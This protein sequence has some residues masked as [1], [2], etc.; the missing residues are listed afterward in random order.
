MSSR[1]A[2]CSSCFP[3][4]QTAPAADQ[5]GRISGRVTVEG[6]NTPMSGA[7]VMLM[8][9][10]RPMGPLGPLPQAA[11]DQDGRQFGFGRS[12]RAQYRVNAQ[13]RPIV[14]RSVAPRPHR[15]GCT[16]SVGRPH[17]SAARE[18]RQ[19]SPGASSILHGEALPEARIH[20]AAQDTR[21]RAPQARQPRL[22]ARAD[23]GKQQTNDLG[24]FRV[25]GPPR[26]RVLVARVAARPS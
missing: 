7:R 17:R 9:T 23:E 18:G 15:S 2:V 11:T 13:G 25:A 24:E 14:A 6:A 16:G 4:S 10:T 22:D 19:S 8:P 3:F 5:A 21:A 1:S 12:H 26:P 20:G